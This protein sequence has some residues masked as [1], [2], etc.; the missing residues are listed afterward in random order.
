MMTDDWWVVGGWLV[1]GWWVISIGSGLP[2]CLQVRP[3]GARKVQGGS[4]EAR[5]GPG[6]Q[7]K[8]RNERFGKQKNR[9]FEPQGA[10]GGLRGR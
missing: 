9:E 10:S 1:G 3:G 5:R 6:S 7:E 8:L 4:G 2:G